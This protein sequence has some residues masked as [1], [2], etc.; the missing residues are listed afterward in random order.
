MGDNH[1]W[2]PERFRA[3][4][5]LQVRLMRRDKRVQARFDSS[6]VVQETLKRAHQNLASCTAQTEP[7]FVKWLDVILGNALIDEER[8]HHADKRDVKK[9]VWMQAAI[10]ESS[11][12]LENYLAEKRR[13]PSGLVEQKEMRLRIMEAVAQL[14][15]DQREVVI[16]RDLELS[17]VSVIAKRLSKTE[18]AVAGLLLRG[19]LKLRQLLAE[20]Q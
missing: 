10:G 3:M 2:Q 13:T 17:P 16:Q 12:R 6:D 14:P 7:E 20:F 11:V 18:K 19:R 8:K 15:D 5:S 4:L 9:E 1:H